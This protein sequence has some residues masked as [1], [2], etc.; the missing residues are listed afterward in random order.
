MM[1]FIQGHQDITAA[2]KLEVTQYLIGHMG[3]VAEAELEAATSNNETPAQ[4]KAKAVG[5]LAHLNGLSLEGLME[6]VKGSKQV[7][8]GDILDVTERIYFF[9]DQIRKQSE[10]PNSEYVDIPHKSSPQ[11][12]IAMRVYTPKDKPY[13]TSYSWL[14]QE[15]TF[16]IRKDIALDPHFLEALEHIAPE[17][18]TQRGGNRGS[19]GGNYSFLDGGGDRY[20]LGDLKVIADFAA[21]FREWEKI[22]RESPTEPF[23]M[24]STGQRLKARI[25]YSTHPITGERRDISDIDI[26]PEDLPSNDFPLAAFH[27]T[28]EEPQL[29]LIQ[30]SAVNTLEGDELKV[31]DDASF[32]LAQASSLKKSNEA[33]QRSKAKERADASK[34]I[35]DRFKVRGASSS[36]SKL[37][38]PQATNVAPSSHNSVSYRAKIS[39]LDLR[40]S[41]GVYLP[42]VADIQSRDILLQD[43][44]NYH[45]KGV[46][47]PED[48]NEGIHE[49]GKDA[50]RRL[51]ESKSA[52]LK[53]GGDLMSLLI[54]EPVV[55]VTI[56]ESEIIVSPVE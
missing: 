6:V 53:D 48:T 5:K 13:Q 51:F 17:N 23:A 29:W 16:Y 35:D 39:A 32:F 41:S 40:N 30:S 45:Q 11:G 46:R 19:S 31:L 38:K 4:I 28:G 22:A 50:L 52:R 25:E 34:S 14:P 9:L 37:G 54:S 18:L 24:L 21:Q 55:E 43:R 2:D 8:A 3:I 56:D 44:F 12:W 20:S 42:E 49:E 36:T 7:E 26:E 15:D 1:E 33:I 10:Q 47:D 27:W